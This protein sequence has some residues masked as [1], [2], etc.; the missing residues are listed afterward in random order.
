M[1][2]ARRKILGGLSTEASPS[3]N[4]VSTWEVEVWAGGGVRE[5]GWETKGIERN[6][7]FPGRY[8]EPGTGV[9]MIKDEKEGL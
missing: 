4:L 2:S 6:W 5:V 7:T 3:P 1:A 8:I 9:L